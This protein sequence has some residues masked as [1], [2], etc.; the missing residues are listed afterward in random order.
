[1]ACIRRIGGA[2][3]LFAILTAIMTWP[4]VLV[5]STHAR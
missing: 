3:G 2:T 4:Q 5:L 1:M